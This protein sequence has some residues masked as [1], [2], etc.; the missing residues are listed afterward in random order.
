M[1]TYEQMAIREALRH[2]TLTLSPD[3]EERLAETMVISLHEQRYRLISDD[4]SFD[5]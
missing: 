2:S 3:E 5:D 1:V 4:S